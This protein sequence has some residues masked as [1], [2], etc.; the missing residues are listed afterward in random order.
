M[1]L[2]KLTNQELN[3]RLQNLVQ[4]E[5]EILKDII[6]HI[7]EVHRRKLFLRMGY[8]S[9]FAYMTE[10]L[11]YSASSAM[12]RIDA[13]RLV[14]DVPE[15]LNK[16]ESGELNLSQVSLLQQSLRQVQKTSV[17]VSL[18]KKVELVNAV[19]GLNKQQTEIQLAKA[20]DIPVIKHNTQ[21]M[22][23]DESVKVELCFSKE[24]WQ[25]VQLMRELI[26]HSV[27]GDLKEAIL[28]ISRKIKK[29]K[30]GG[31]LKQLKNQVD[32][33]NEEKN[34][35]KNK[36]ADI[37][38]I[39]PSSKPIT[40]INNKLM[41]MPNS[42]SSNEKSYD[43]RNEIYNEQKAWLI[44]KNNASHQA[45]IN[46]KINTSL[47][48]RKS[49]PQALKRKV[50]QRF[51]SCQYTDKTSHKKCNSQWQLQLEHI[52]PVWANGANDFENLTVLCGMHNRF[53]YQRQ[54]GL[55]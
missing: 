3:L 4:Q 40:K 6:L 49:I 51:N 31:N 48:P 21:K 12:R 38:C 30:M 26:S 22:Q 54:I 27:T 44:T 33:S 36:V 2:S 50:F 8:S 45:N 37:P 28:H 10:Y 47:P 29:Q 23:A 41:N 52:Q 15:A 39:K 20:L 14:K 24:E 16:I 1:N 7:Q 13:A 25:E 35:E 43:T 17:A 11:Q 46:T 9:L 53:Q 42:E 32:V 19:I 5:R 55:K 34:K 18:D